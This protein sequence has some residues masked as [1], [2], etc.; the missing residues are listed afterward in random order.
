MKTWETLLLVIMALATCGLVLLV[1][2]FFV[3]T[4][5]PQHDSINVVEQQMANGDMCYHTYKF[6]KYESTS[7][8]PGTANR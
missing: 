6:L 8:V 2:A 1:A 4:P 7:C 3:T 5:F